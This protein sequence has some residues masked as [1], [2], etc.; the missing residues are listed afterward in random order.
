MLNAQVND[1]VVINGKYNVNKEYYKTVIYSNTSKKNKIGEVL[2]YKGMPISDTVW[3]VYDSFECNKPY[4][5]IS[6]KPKNYFYDVHSKKAVLDFY[7]DSSEHSYYLYSEK[8]QILRDGKKY[9][10]VSICDSVVV[11]IENI[12]DVQGVDKSS[13][14]VNSKAGTT[15][16]D[17]KNQQQ[18]FYPNAAYY[19]NLNCFCFQDSA[20][21]RY[22]GTNSNSLYKLDFT[23]VISN[24]YSRN[25]I[26]KKGDKFGL[27]DHFPNSFKEGV[28]E[29]SNGG[30]PAPKYKVVIEYTFD[31]LYR[32]SYPA[33]ISKKENKFGLIYADE[34]ILKPIY[35]SIYEQGAFYIYRNK[36]DGINKY[37][38]VYNKTVLTEPIFSAV[39]NTY[40]HYYLVQ[41]VSKD[42]SYVYA[43]DA[44]SQ[45]NRGTITNQLIDIG[46]GKLPKN[47]HCYKMKSYINSF[48]KEFY[49][50]NGD[51]V[52]NNKVFFISSTD[53]V[54]YLIYDS[55]VIHSFKKKRGDILM[56]VKNV[57]DSN[58]NRVTRKNDSEYVS[59][60][61]LFEF[62]N[63][64]K[65]HNAYYW[66]STQSGFEK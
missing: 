10:F 11:E 35:D 41:D 15:L 45:S 37:G 31:S 34:E 42:S 20:C 62:K 52:Y 49:M 50:L 44:V 16:Y 65:I 26:V 21:Y 2:Y 57:Y 56:S 22:D 33:L 12:Y 17:F 19:T 64:K 9:Y 60:Q 14:F 40:G 13:V 47:I 29:K 48:E 55:K 4:L 59:T 6:N 7:F 24:P 27:I 61:F 43:F 46:K 39:I 5:Q 54:Y 3:Y 1:T 58:G 66:Y 25:W 30:L 63:K 36:V 28:F 38:L 32:F 53:K 23:N 8:Q 18:I 51:P